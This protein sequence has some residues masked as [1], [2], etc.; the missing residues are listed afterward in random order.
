MEGLQ[1]NQGRYV[2][3]WRRKVPLSWRAWGRPPPN[4][5]DTYNR[6]PF[7][8]TRKVTSTSDPLTKKYPKIMDTSEGSASCQTPIP[9]PDAL[10]PGTS[11]ATSR[12]SPALPPHIV[13]V[14]GGTWTSVGG[15][16]I[17]FHIYHQDRL[18]SVLSAI[19]LLVSCVSMVLIITYGRNFAS[20]VDRNGIPCQ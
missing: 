16:V 8:T 1:G 19:A 4:S 18:T 10:E 11:K 13:R 3:I 12:Y 9:S 15:D 20:V 2:H 6:Q 14:N 7:E 17:N 5:C